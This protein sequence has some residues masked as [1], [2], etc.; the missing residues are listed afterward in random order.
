ML[1]T[2]IIKDLILGNI[3]SRW[4]VEVNLFKFD[5][6][7]ALDRLAQNQLKCLVNSLRVHILVGYNIYSLISTGY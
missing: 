7:E 6:F 5:F 4:E 2:H 3:L 1:W